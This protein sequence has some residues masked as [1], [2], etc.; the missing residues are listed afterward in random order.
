MDDDDVMRPPAHAH[1]AGGMSAFDHVRY[2]LGWWGRAWAGGTIDELVEL[3]QPGDLLLFRG[4]GVVAAAQEL[5]AGGAE[6]HV[7]IVVSVRGTKCYAQSDRPE[8]RPQQDCLVDLVEPPALPPVR[9]A[10]VDTAH[11][12]CAMTVVLL[13][14]G[15]L[16]YLEHHGI[17]VCLRRLVVR[18][19]RP[20]RAEI[21][22]ATLNLV[23]RIRDKNVPF[24]PDPLVF[25]GVRYPWLAAAVATA[26]WFCGGLHPAEVHA[27]VQHGMYCSQ[28]VWQAY[29]AAGLLHDDYAALASAHGPAPADFNAHAEPTLSAYR[30]PRGRPDAA[31]ALPGALPW[32]RP[33]VCGLG[34]PLFVR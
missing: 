32:R 33:G 22:A 20:S 6:S 27:H 3:A 8:H 16:D 17:D 23:E 34:A 29:V 31:G 21:N 12:E 13:R 10:R 18:D 26:R 30:V 2:A 24:E 1:R 5:F 15:L 7:A 9:G 4:R 19:T 28:F 25:V 11:A 14:E